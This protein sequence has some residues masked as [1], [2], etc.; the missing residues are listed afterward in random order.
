LKRDVEKKLQR[1]D[2]RTQK[3]IYE[4]IRMRLEKDKDANFAEV[5]ANAETQ[6]NFLEEDA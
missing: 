3:A 6:Q 1:L 5:V 4:I 2:K